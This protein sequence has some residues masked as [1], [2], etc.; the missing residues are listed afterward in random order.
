VPTKYVV[1]PNGGFYLDFANK[2]RQMSNMGNPSTKVT[3]SINF[4]C[5][6]FAL[7]KAKTV[8]RKITTVDTEAPTL[9][10]RGA[11]KSV[12]YSQKNC[13]TQA[14]C[15]SADHHKTMLCKNSKNCADEGATAEDRCDKNVNDADITMSWGPRKFNARKLGDY[16]RTY[17]V[18]D[19]AKNV[20]SITRTFVVID[21]DKPIIKLQGAQLETY[22]A[23]REV[24]YTDKGATCEDWV[25]GE[26]S[27]AVE[28]SGEVVNMRIPGTYQIRYD[29]QDLTGNTAE[30]Q[31]RKVVIEDTISPE[32][33]LKGAS[34]N[35][36]EAGFPYLDAGA[37][38]TDTLD[39]DITQYIWTD[40]NTVDD[41]R[42]FYAFPSCEAMARNQKALNS[43]E[44]YITTTT[45]T[46]AYKR[47]LVHCAFPSKSNSIKSA[48]TFFVHHAKDVTKTCRSVG[49][50]KMQPTK[51][52]SAYINEDGILKG[53]EHIGNL[54]EYLCTVT[55]SKIDASDKTF[56]QGALA[57]KIADA[58]QGKYIINFHVE[59]KAGNHAKVLYRTVIVKDTLPPVVTLHLQKKLIAVSARAQKG[60]NGQAN[61]KGADIHGHEMY[62]AEVSTSNGF[63]LAAVAS[64]VAG[65]ALLGV[66]MR[67]TVTSVPV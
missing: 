29:C 54:D 15:E 49:M 34:V 21:E 13:K 37:T 50:K 36:L 59:D 51:E 6:D 31:Y 39:G 35:Y 44:Y 16:V 64:A 61:T 2:L 56:G 63:V 7:N 24:E 47:V 8:T 4:D 26:L 62:M 57:D 27:H 3:R 43:G 41:Q 23:N 10:L 48:F 5:Q 12:E 67:K 52:Q 19:A 18:K 9:A 53:Y 46:G 42:A 20:K 1:K 66:S 17:T 14:Q 60:L 28:V 40:G 25:D 38:A 58:E 22:Q 11:Q 45:K 55:D 33:S 32:L 30:F 65:V